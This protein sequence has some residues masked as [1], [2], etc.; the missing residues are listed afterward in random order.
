MD[1]SQDNEV[2]AVGDAD[3]EAP[4]AQR[5]RLE[6]AGD[7]ER[8]PEARRS[9]DQRPLAEGPGIV[10][11]CRG[12]VNGNTMQHIVIQRH[13]SVCSANKLEQSQCQHDNL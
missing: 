9:T 10:T 13:S 3:D 12:G 2:P 6:G 5:R 11:N 4:P 8:H 7:N 1:D